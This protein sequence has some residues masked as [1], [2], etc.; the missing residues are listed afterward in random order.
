MG[1]GDLV[2]IALGGEGHIVDARGDVLGV[3]VVLDVGDLDLFAVFERPGRGACPGFKVGVERDALL[4][5]LDL[6]EE[7]HRV[8]FFL[9][10]LAFDAVLR[11][12]KNFDGDARFVGGGEGDGVVASLGLDV[13]LDGLDGDGLFGLGVPCL[14][15]GEGNDLGLVELLYVLHVQKEGIRTDLLALFLIENGAILRD[16][17][18]DGDGGTDARFNHRFI[19]H[20]LE[21]LGLD[22]AL[23]HALG[24]GNDVKVLGA[25]DHV[26]LLVLVVSAGAAGELLILEH[27]KIIFEH[28]AVDDVRLADELGDEFVDG[29]AVDLG[30]RTN[31][32]N[33]TRVHH[34]DL[35]RHRQRLF[36]VVRDEDEGDADLLLDVLE[37]LLHLL[38]Q[39]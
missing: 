17:H 39:L 21:E 23:E 1:G 36:L 27:D 33:F 38:A 7:V 11:N 19:V 4:N 5:I 32:L 8:N 22:R 37:L 20:A 34:H 26:D 31:L 16:L 13:V 29:S 3:K 9:I 14:S 35:I 18:L 12:D 25:N 24:A 10:D 6:F 30:R 2:L 15:G 28:D